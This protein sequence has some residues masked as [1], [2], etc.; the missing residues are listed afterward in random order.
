MIC[1][2]ND[3]KNKFFQNKSSFFINLILETKINSLFP[4]LGSLKLVNS[5]QGN[6]NA[7]ITNSKIAK[8]VDTQI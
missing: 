3:L 8:I 6:V 5:I 2:K 7:S 1:A 4:L